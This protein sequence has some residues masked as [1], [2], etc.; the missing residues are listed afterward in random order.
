MEMKYT[1][2][3]VEACT[4]ALIVEAGKFSDPVH[5]YVEN[6]AAWRRE[7]VDP[8]YDRSADPDATKES[9]RILVRAVLEAVDLGEH[10]DQL[11]RDYQSD[12]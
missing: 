1:E 4:E 2:E 11:R 6:E 10:D 7:K 12:T 5:F 8:G 9:W 3:Q